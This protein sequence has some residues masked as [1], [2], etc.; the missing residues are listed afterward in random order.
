MFDR[1]DADHSGTISPI[2]MRQGMSNPPMNLD[3]T[4]QQFDKVSRL[5]VQYN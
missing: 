4:D 1:F 5:Q 3:F 2:E